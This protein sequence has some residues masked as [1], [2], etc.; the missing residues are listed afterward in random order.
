MRLNGFVLVLAAMLGSTRVAAAQ[1][2]RPL[3]PGDIDDIA[4]LVMLEDHREFDTT[5]LSRLLASS[6]PEVRRR[7]CWAIGRIANKSGYALLRAKS[8]DAD[9]AVAATEV[10]A[11]GQLKDSN[12]VAWFD[13]LAYDPKL[14]PTAPRRK[15]ATALGKSK[16]ARGA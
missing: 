16:T 11:A 15:A 8:L 7:A 10:F 5:D 4:R 13:S 1:S 2:R 6:H 3:S 9:T 14:A 12:T